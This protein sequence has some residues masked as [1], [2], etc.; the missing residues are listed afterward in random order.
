MSVKNRLAD[1]DQRI[2]RL[3]VERMELLEEYCKLGERVADFEAQRDQL[4]AR[5]GYYDGEV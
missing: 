2:D 5:T 4:I 3:V 1:L